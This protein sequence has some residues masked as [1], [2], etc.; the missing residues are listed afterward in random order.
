MNTLQRMAAWLMVSLVAG[1]GGGGSDAGSS[2]YTASGPGAPLYGDGTGTTTPTSIMVTASSSTLDS[3]GDPLT[4][5]AVVKDSSGALLAGVA[6][7]FSTGAGTA[8]TAV[9]TV[10]NAVGVASAVLSV[11]TDKSVR[12]VNVNVTAGSLNATLVLGVTGTTLAY[13]G[14]TATTVGTATDVGVKLTDSK[15]V[16]ISGI[17]VTIANTNTTSNHLSATTATTDAQGNISIVFTPGALGSDTLFFTGA[18]TTA[19]AAIAIN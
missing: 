2:L 7:T 8:L 10:T 3:G 18:G 15:G 13:T 9:D 14:P 4:L 6:V 12:N 19:T 11:T 5:T 17:A 1:C 16:A